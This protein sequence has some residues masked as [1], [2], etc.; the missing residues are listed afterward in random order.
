MEI[1][2]SRSGLVESKATGHSIIS[3]IERTYLTAWA[4]RA[5]QERA[6]AVEVC[7]PSKH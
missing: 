4:G 3:S 5:A 2:S 1:V 6:P 7:Q